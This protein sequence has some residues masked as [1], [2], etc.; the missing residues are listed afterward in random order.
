[1]NAVK[2][3]KLKKWLHKN[4]MFICGAGSFILIGLIGA[5]IGFEIEQKGHAI[6]KWLSSPQATTFLICAILGAFVI[7]LM[8]AL[9][10]ITRRGDDY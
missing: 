10:I 7:G 8:V 1:M 5:L 3:R 2:K 4:R 9:L 6:R